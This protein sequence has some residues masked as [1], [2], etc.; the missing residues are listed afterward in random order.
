MRR[1]EVWVANLNLNRGAEIG[2]AR[3]VLVLQADWFSRSQ[4]Y[5]VVV[6][7]LTAQVRVEA[8]PLRVTLK[9]RDRLLRDCQVVVEQPRT[10]DRRRIGE[11]PLTT[12][13]TAEL[14]AVEQSLLSV[15][16]IA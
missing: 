3:P 10:V 2:K 1:G 9:A 13:T 7:P 16:G 14:V 6:L 15:L 8:E 5:T 4:A 12:L 11:G